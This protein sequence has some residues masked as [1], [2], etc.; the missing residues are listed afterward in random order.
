M[1][2]HP[3]ASI[4]QRN[5]FPFYRFPTNE[6]LAPQQKSLQSLKWRW[7]YYSIA[8]S[9]FL[10]LDTRKSFKKIITVTKMHEKLS[11]PSDSFPMTN[12]TDVQNLICP[13]GICWSLHWPSRYYIV[14]MHRKRFDLSNLFIPPC[15]SH[16]IKRRNNIRLTFNI[17]IYCENKVPPLN[18]FWCSLDLFICFQSFLWKP[19]VS[20]KPIS[21]KA[22]GAW[23]SKI[24][25][26]IIRLRM[27]NI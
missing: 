25:R 22:S 12:W 5:E 17:E 7:I 1:D 3:F 10:P 2:I 18:Q 15:D 11:R 19:F 4:H 6:K 23:N 14:S 27:S 9:L 8:S 16:P 24:F 20:F 26:F 13:A 21:L